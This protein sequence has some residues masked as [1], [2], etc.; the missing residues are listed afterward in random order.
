MSTSLRS[1]QERTLASA[2]RSYSIS[3]R[4]LFAV[5]DL[6][7]GKEA[8]LEKFRVLEVVARVP[9]MAWEHVGYAA[10][11][12]THETPTFAR[13]IHDRVVEA[14]AQQDNEQW[15]LLIIE[16]LLHARG[17]RHSLVRGRLLPQVMAVV[18]YQL[19]WLLFSIRPSMSYRM[20]ADFEDHAEHEYMAYVRDHPELEAE[21]W[22]SVFRSDYDAGPTLADLFRQIGDDER[23]H[24][25]ESEALID[26]AR[27]G[28]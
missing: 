20:N 26:R 27:F 1:Q 16:E 19:S 22:E 9:Y 15:H 18:Y 7:Y 10:I 14:R 6:V 5:M 3:A 23:H 4:M 17:V 13:E 11:T 24:K 12:H 8:T 2:R 28:R 21:P 25:E